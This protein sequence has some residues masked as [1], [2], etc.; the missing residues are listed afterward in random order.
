MSTRT[1]HAGPR[2]PRAVEQAPGSS[3]A[4]LYLRKDAALK[5]GSTFNPARGLT[6]FCKPG[7]W[8][9]PFCRQTGSQMLSRSPACSSARPRIK[10]SQR[11][12]AFTVLTR[13]CRC[14]WRF[15]PFC[16][17]T[18]SQMLSQT[19]ACSSARPRPRV[20]STRIKE[21]SAPRHSPFSPDFADVVG[22]FHHFVA[23][24]AVKCFR[25]LRHVHQ[26]ARGLAC[27]ARG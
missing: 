11:A 4:M 19:P 16:R 15:S 20:R 27:A 24:L 7:H 5:G 14:R 2:S 1:E 23:S 12:A 8:T 25:E 21:V 13:F 26:C 9:S 17:Q 3:P 6:R 18:G 10:K 22:G